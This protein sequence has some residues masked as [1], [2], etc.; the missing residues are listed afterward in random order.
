M[1]N[2]RVKQLE[3]FVTIWEEMLAKSKE[4]VATLNRAKA[5]GIS[6]TDHNGKDILPD[7]ISQEISVS[8]EFYKGLVRAKAQLDRA[9]NGE[10]A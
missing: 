4:K 8:D 6:L 3:D 10:E 1:T 9:K 2:E 7:R 5:I